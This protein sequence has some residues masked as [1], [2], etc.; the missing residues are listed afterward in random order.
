MTKAQ[1]TKIKTDLERR[2]ISYLPNGDY[3]LRIQQYDYTYE[4]SLRHKDHSTVAVD[5]L[6][7]ILDLCD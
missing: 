2:G 3:I 7:Y 1:R 5:R 4:Y 6:N